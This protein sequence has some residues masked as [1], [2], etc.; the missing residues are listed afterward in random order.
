[1]LL[2]LLLRRR[3][4][5]SQRLRK[6]LL[7]SQ[8]QLIALK[9]F[10]L[11]LHMEKKKLMARLLPNLLKTVMFWTK[12]SQRPTSTLFLQKLRTRPPERLTSCSSRMLS[13]CVQIRE[14][15]AKML[16]RQPFLLLVGQY[17]AAQKQRPI[18]SMMISH[19]TQV[20]TL[21]E[22]PQMLTKIKSQISLKHLIALLPTLEASKNDGQ[23]F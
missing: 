1:M 7:K 22:A 6:K 13:N 11:V 16:C 18:S 4:N 23:K 10:L 2:G 20:C 17:S 3:R 21:R 19:F 15:K 12:R 8:L 14:R 9:Q 5:R